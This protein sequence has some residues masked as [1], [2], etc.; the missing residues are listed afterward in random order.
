MRS[1]GKGRQVKLEP[2]KITC[3]SADCANGLHCFKRS[4]TMPP[5]ERGRCRYCGVDLIDWE[6]FHER[7]LSDAKYKFES[8]RC[9]FV[10]HHFWHKPIDLRA[11]NH[12]RRKGRIGLKEAARQ[13]LGKSVAPAF[14]P[15]DGRQTPSK[16]NVIYYAQLSLACCCRTCIEY[17]HG[18]PKGIA[19]SDEELDYFVEL[20][21]M[22]VDE[23]MPNLTDSGEKVPYIQN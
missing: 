16:G 9:E 5:A 11:Q 7:D 3:I 6:R 12:A 21:M 19:L 2:L 1:K 17:W 15:Y 10:R 23:R 8:L 22:Y 14:P 4:R 18:I 13:R 20:V